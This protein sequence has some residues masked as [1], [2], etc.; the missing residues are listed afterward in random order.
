MPVA[1]NPIFAPEHVEKLIKAAR[2]NPI[3][4][5]FGLGA[6]PEKSVLAVDKLKPGKVLFE[7]CRKEGG[8]RKGAYGTVQFAETCPVF[9]CEKDEVPTLAKAILAYFKANKINLRVEIAAASETEEA[10]SEEP[11]SAPAET[12]NPQPNATGEDDDGPENQVFDPP[13]II[14]LIRKARSQAFPFAFGVADDRPLLA[15]HRR[16]DPVRLARL[17]RAEGARRGV[18][19]TV[20]LDGSVA[21]FTCEKEPFPGVK[22]GIRQWFKDQRLAARFRVVGP[23]GEVDEPE[24]EDEVEG[25]S[26]HEGNAWAAA[27]ANWRST[28]DTVGGQ[29][30]SLAAALRKTGSPRLMQIAETGLSEMIGGCTS[31]VEAALRDG[32]PDAGSTAQARVA[33]A[34]KSAR[35]GLKSDPR[36]AA[37]ENNPF[38]IQVT[39]TASINS[40][41][42]R[43]EN[44]LVEGN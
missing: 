11:E 13:N 28:I 8:A 9:T 12:A 14:A 39:L 36:V 5:A 35:D 31:D 24:E 7:L 19:G 4:F 10:Q 16:M 26:H 15:V 32:R 33:A 30:A 1:T 41:L 20:L 34:I 37:S 43:L 6:T 40:A 25:E 29:L 22:R 21:V 27:V 3:F 44:S 18:W 42:T 23:S 38:G 17:V 2:E